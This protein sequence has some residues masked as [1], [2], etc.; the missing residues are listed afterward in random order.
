[1]IDY[2]ISKSN[3]RVQ[4]LSLALI[5]M[6]ASS[7]GGIEYLT[8]GT[9]DMVRKYYEQISHVADLTV[10]H[11]FGLAVFY[12]FSSH[13]DFALHLLDCKIDSYIMDFLQRYDAK[14][15]I[16]SFFPIFYTALS[17]NI[18]TSP[19]T[20]EK[21]GKFTT[22]YSP[23]LIALLEFFKKDLP[24]AAHQTVLEIFKYMFGPK[25]VYFRDLLIEARAQE[26]LRIY[27]SSLQSMFSGNIILRSKATHS[28]TSCRTVFPNDQRYSLRKA[29]TESKR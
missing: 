27:Y 1:M 8:Q 22:R 5:S 26:T 12:K 18:L 17:Y 23:L 29:K 13:K 21:I 6:I 10:A 25:E 19:S 16:H 14:K 3:P 9:D 7:Q 28:R 24:S 4:T 20:Q 2:L 11:R 15:G